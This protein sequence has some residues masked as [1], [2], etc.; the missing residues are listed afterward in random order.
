MVTVGNLHKRFN[1]PLFQVTEDS[2]I[3][4]V[5]LEE[6]IAG[7][8]V[9]DASDVIRILPGAIE[10]S[11]DIT[12]NVDKEYITGIVKVDERLLILLESQ[13]LLATGG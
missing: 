1:L 4:I 8:M 6:T 3:I 13:K 2:R 9:D 7:I 5:K 11:P 10:N 12:G